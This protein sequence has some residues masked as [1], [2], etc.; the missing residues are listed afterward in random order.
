LLSSLYNNFT[1]SPKIY[2]WDHKGYEGN[3]SRIQ[4]ITTKTKPNVYIDS[5]NKFAHQPVI[6]KQG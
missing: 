5:Q 6:K 2:H 4:T 3:T 1:Y